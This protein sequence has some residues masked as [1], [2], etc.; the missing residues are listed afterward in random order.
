MLKVIT[1]CKNPEILIVT[2]LLKTDEITHQISRETKI[3]IKRNDIDFI[4]TTYSGP[5]K[6]AKNCQLGIEAF[7]QEFHFLPRYIFILDR[8]IIAGRNMLDKFYKTLS[9]TNEKIAYVYCPFEYKGHINLK[10]PPTVWDYSLL[11][12]RNYISSNSLYK[13]ELL[14]KVGGFVI[15]LDTHRLSDWALWLKFARNGYKGILCSN[16]YF[17]A[18]STEKDISAGGQE[19]YIKTRELVLKRYVQN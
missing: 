19:E 9:L 3:S 12:T 13:T 10:I 16:T 7:Q 15:D 5:D 1:E 6:H 2:P 8:D 18:I 17:T 4:W 14:Q 11:K